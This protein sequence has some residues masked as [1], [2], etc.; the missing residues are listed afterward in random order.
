MR[1]C[2]SVNVRLCY[3]PASGAQEWSEVW[4]CMTAAP[5]LSS[6]CNRW[7]YTLHVVLL[8]NR[9]SSDSLASV[10]SSLSLLFFFKAQSAMQLVYSSETHTGLIISDD[11]AYMM[12]RQPFSSVTD[13]MVRSMSYTEPNDLTRCCPHPRCSRSATTCLV[14]EVWLETWFT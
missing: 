10:L 11:I 12:S 3:F 4:M 9:P 2:V 5:A 6:R 1:E 7:M 14:S 13:A 8:L